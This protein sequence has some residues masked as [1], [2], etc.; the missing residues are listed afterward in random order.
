MMD[1][2]NREDAPGTPGTENAEAET[3]GLRP[4]EGMP[5]QAGP[6]RGDPA[7]PDPGE[8][9]E[10]PRGPGAFAEEATPPPIFDE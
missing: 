9:V 8:A 5:T 7:A 3:S 10:P 6:L 2:R 4:P 1:A